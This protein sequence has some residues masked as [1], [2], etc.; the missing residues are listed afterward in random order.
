MVA[1]LATGVAVALVPAPTIVAGAAITVVAVLVPN[2]SYVP[3][4]YLALVAGL[5]CGYMMLGRGFAYLGAGP[6]YVGELVLGAGTLLLALHGRASRPLHPGVQLVIVSLG[7]FMIWGAAATIPYVGQY[8][9]AALR[10]AAVWGYGW[11]ALL[12][13]A[14]LRSRMQLER[15]LGF[16]RAV[17]PV[18]LAWALLSDL[19]LRVAPERIPVLPS[20][21][22]PLLDLKPG[23][24]GVHLAGVA[25]FLLLRLDRPTTGSGAGRRVWMEPL[26]WILWTVDFVLVAARNRGG[27]LAIL[28]ALAAVAA[29]ERSGRLVK[30]TAAAIAFLI[31]VTVL[32]VRIAAPGGREVSAGQVAANFSS[33]LADAN[34]PE[35]ATTKNWRMAWWRQIVSYTVH[36]RWFWTGKGYGVN[37]A[38]D[39]GFQVSADN[40]LRSPHNAGLTILARSGVPGFALWVLVQATFGAMLLATR[41]RFR[42]LGDRRLAAVCVWILAYWLAMLSNAAFDVY[43]EGPQGAIWF[44]T[45]L[46]LGLAMTG[47]SADPSKGPGHINGS[48]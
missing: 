33:I 40:S 4:I 20:S 25:A 17:L 28:V 24:V 29:L 23:D 15:L 39:D 22:V 47:F 14:M 42:Q 38:D 48:P 3:M 36:G 26:L 8:G 34:H 5:L 6:V 19:V 45:I 7:L 10:D 43:L 32:G 31:L 2:R 1:S 13:M 21:G 37:L 46:G 16:Y 41:R 9:L 44:W 30:P 18:F 12:A 27:G 11:F 35:L